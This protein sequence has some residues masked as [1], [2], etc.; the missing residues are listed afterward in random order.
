MIAL[1]SNVLIQLALAEHEAHERTVAAV[2]RE[3]R[4]GR[5][6]ALADLVVTEFLHVVT[7]PRRFSPPLTMEEA[8]AWLSRFIEVQE[9]KLLFSSPRALEQ[10]LVWL[11]QF[12]LGRK[13]VL[14]THLTAILHTEGVRRLVT[15]N[16][17]D[18][19]V[20]GVLDF[21]VPA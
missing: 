8:S 4:E 15:S 20:F 14:D 7:D 2:E 1:D 12:R 18:F 13:R 9:V 10:T 17:A 3:R 16:A 5:G 6:L 11:R 21:V 19:A